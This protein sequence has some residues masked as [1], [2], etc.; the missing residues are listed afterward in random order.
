MA[1]T[2]AIIGRGNGG[3]PGYTGDG[4]DVA[5]I[6]TG[7]SPVEGLAT[8]GK[9]INGPD[10][11][12]ESQAPNL[13]HLDTNGHGT[14]MA[15]LIA[16]HDSDLDH[17]VLDTRPIRQY[18]GVAPDA[19]I[20]SVKVGTAD[21]GVDVTQVIAAI[22][23]VVQHKDDNGMNI[24][25]LNLSYGTNSSARLRLIDPLSY[26]VEQAWKAG[27][28]VVAA[29]GNTGYQTGHGRARSRRSRVQP[30]RDRGRR[31]RPRTAPRA[32]SDDTVG[33]YSASGTGC[34]GCRNPD[35]V[36]PGSHVQG[37]RVPN[38]YVD[39]NHPE[40]LLGDRYFRGSGTSEAAAITSGAVALILQKYPNM[41]PDAV[42]NFMQAQRVPAVRSWCDWTSTAAGSGELSLSKLATAWPSM[43]STQ[44][45][46]A[47]TGTGSLEAARG[48]DHLTANGVTLTGEQDIFGHAVRLDRNG[49]RTKPTA[50]AGP[51][52]SG[53]AARGRDRAG[54]GAA[55]RARRW[56]GSSWSGRVGPA[57]PG[58]VRPGPGAVGRVR[59]G[60]ALPGRV[61]PGRAAAGPGTGRWSGS[62]WSGAA[63]RVRPGPAVTGASDWLGVTAAG[64]SGGRSRGRTSRKRTWRGNFRRGTRTVTASRVTGE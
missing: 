51:A 26:A 58:R 12:L 5:V 24:R 17:A 7:V 61:R 20:V 11:S 8:P 62:S 41:T 46:P 28:V 30:L 23:W 34:F 45:W 31:L 55:G 57:R 27:I 29:A 36:A 40:G 54:Q 37:L 15:G 18:R 48:S 33:P 38:S 43:N 13:T 52:A 19:R 60:P 49:R 63:G 16:G 25:V 47:A 10:L 59:A 44:T 14:F 56:S 2:T 64:A 35:F 3:T 39:V 42:K 9:I 53:T 4:V 50:P 22:D 21:G 6:D 1:K 32:T